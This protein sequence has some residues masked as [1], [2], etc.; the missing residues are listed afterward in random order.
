MC[1]SK[2]VL[3]KFA[4]CLPPTW[5]VSLAAAPVHG[6]RCCLLHAQHHPQQPLALPLQRLPRRLALCLGT[7]AHRP[8]LLL[9]L[10]RAPLLLRRQRLARRP[11]RLPLQLLQRGL[12]R[13]PPLLCRQ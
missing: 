5:H 10:R 12:L 1:C 7:L 13:L 4:C 9:L 3:Y 2:D 6:R 8:L 11:H